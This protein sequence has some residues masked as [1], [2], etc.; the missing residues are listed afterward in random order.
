[1]TMTSAAAHLFQGGSQRRSVVGAGAAVN[2][3][4]DGLGGQVA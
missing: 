2:C 1:M 4:T 3:G